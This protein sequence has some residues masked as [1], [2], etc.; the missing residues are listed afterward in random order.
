[1][2]FMIKYFFYILSNLKMNKIVFM[3]L[4]SQKFFKKLQKLCK[5]ILSKNIISSEFEW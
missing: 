4:K 2:I 1:M 5:I 3:N